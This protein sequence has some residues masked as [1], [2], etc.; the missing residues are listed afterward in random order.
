[1]GIVG[2]TSLVV[3]GGSSITDDVRNLHFQ[4]CDLSDAGKYE[5]AISTWR[6]IWPKVKE[7]N[8]ELRYKIAINIACA[9]SKWWS[10]C[11]TND[12]AMTSEHV[13]RVEAYLIE[14]KNVEGTGCSQ[15][16]EILERLGEVIKWYKKA[17]AQGNAKAKEA[18]KELGEVNE[19]ADS[20]SQSPQQRQNKV[21]VRGKYELD[22]PL[23]MARGLGTV[24]MSPCNL[25]RAW[26]L[27]FDDDS[28]DLFIAIVPI[29]ST[30]VMT[31]CMA[32]DAVNGVLDVCT[33]GFYGNWLYTDGYTPWFWQRHNSYRHGIMTEDRSGTAYR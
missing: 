24:V 5:E 17:A 1:M 8:D 13:R 15:E 12:A 30:I 23:G 3:S 28:D 7:S 31:G 29:F 14:A 4:A 20:R 11:G 2:L 9:Y 6:G 22:F 33:F 25:V 27:A 32:C 10:T 19:D 26:P 18:L 21:E 16:K